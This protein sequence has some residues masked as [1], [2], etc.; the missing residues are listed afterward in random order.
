[1]SAC[2]RHCT[3]PRR[4]VLPVAMPC[5]VVAA[6]A[7]AAQSPPVI[8]PKWVVRGL[9]RRERASTCGLI[10]PGIP[11]LRDGEVTVL[12]GWVGVTCGHPSGSEKK[13]VKLC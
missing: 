8:A 2:R 5:V 7:A 12:A 1:M 9:Q 3:P 6:A 11:H 13:G 4:V 10:S